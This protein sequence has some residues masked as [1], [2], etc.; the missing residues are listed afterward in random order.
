LQGGGKELG[1]QE[2][3]V[4]LAQGYKLP[5]LSALEAMVKELGVIQGGVKAARL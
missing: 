3:G 1:I 4:R 5:D 2:L